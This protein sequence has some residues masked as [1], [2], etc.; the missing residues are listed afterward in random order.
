MAGEELHEDAKQLGGGERA[1]KA[2]REGLA[3]AQFCFNFPPFVVLSLIL[4]IF[5][6]SRSRS[7]I[8]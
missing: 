3:N 1:Q 6:Y 8:F 7:K 4:P 2:L 5:I